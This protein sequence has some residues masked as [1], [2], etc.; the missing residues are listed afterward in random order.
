MKEKSLFSYLVLIFGII[1]CISILQC[2]L[3]KE[4]KWQELGNSGKG[5]GISNSGSLAYDPSI[6]VDINNVPI[7]VYK[8]HDREGYVKI[9]KFVDNE[10]VY[11]KNQENGP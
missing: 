2:E 7:V 4:E 8:N 6:R 1:A 5:E 3:D 11:I 10:W 9:K